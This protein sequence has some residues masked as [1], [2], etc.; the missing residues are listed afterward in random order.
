MMKTTSVRDHVAILSVLVMAGT[1][2]CS[3]ISDGAVARSI[4]TITSFS[5]GPDQTPSYPGNLPTLPDEH[6]T[7]FPPGPNSPFYLVFAASSIIGTGGTRGPAGT[8]VLQ[9]SDLQ[10]FDY[11]AGYTSPVMAAPVLFRDCNPTYDVEFD[12][13]YSA[14]GSVVQDPTQP[15][16]NLI[17]I[18][19]AENHCPGGVWQNQ[20]YATV[21]FARSTDFGMTW[22]API[23]SEFGG[24]DRRPVLKTQTPEP[25]TPETP[26]TALGDAIPSAF[27]DTDAKGGHYIYVTYI[28]LGPDDDGL[29]R[30]ARAK[31]IK[32]NA[33][34]DS[35]RQITF[36]K[37]YNGAFSQPGIGGLDSGMTAKRGCSGGQQQGQMSYVPAIGQYLLTFVCAS[38]PL[39]E[40]GWYYS[41]ATDLALQ[42]WTTP[43]LIE[44]SQFALTP[45]CG[46]GG[47]GNSFDGWYPSFMS[48]DHANGHLG[49]TGLVFFLSGC[50]TG[51][52]PPDRTF[53]YRTFT[54]TPSVDCIPP[55]SPVRHLDNNGNPVYLR[56][57]CKDND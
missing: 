41:T 28:D 51:G 3:L 16:G 50:D 13:N 11:A 45:A 21:G 53:L 18:Y 57:P 9:T 14:P 32:D 4:R 19:E 2:T 40:A 46:S 6:M 22:P 23:D 35:N 37:W 15:P 29:L 20:F 12:E 26:P 48:P 54:I 5:I 10:N 31:I 44:N 39:G 43:Q 55:G 34:N 25:T 1:L 47:S 17:M 36:T 49:T 33:G 27:V 30:V 52:G 8:V 7:F 56:E 24:P 38:V 42:D